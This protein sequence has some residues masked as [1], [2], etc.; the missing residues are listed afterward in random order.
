MKWPGITRAALEIA[1]D[2]GGITR[3]RS[4]ERMLG[5]LERWLETQPQDPLPAIDAWL[6]ALSDEDLETV[7]VGE[8]LEVAALMASAPPFTDQ[9]LNAYFEEVC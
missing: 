1:Y 5:Q 7:C 6:L 8:Q 4:E 3:M 2:N 9:L